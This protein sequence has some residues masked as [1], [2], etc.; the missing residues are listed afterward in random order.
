MHVR[1]PTNLGGKWVVRISE[2]KSPIS[3]VIETMEFTSREAAYQAYRQA[4]KEVGRGN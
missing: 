2:T 4:M 1:K 3:P